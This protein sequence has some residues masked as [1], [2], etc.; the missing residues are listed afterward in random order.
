MQKFRQI[1]GEYRDNFVKRNI[2]EKY[3]SLEALR[4][5]PLKWAN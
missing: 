1:V 3:F 2:Y 4:F 5:R